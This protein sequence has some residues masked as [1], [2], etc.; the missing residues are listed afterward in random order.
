MPAFSCDTEQAPS[1]AFP[2]TLAAARSCK[3]RSVTSRFTVSLSGGFALLELLVSIV[4]LALR[5][6]VVTMM[7]DATSMAVKTSSQHMDS[8]SQARLVFDRMA[9][10]FAKMVKRND[11]DCLLYKNPVDG[12]SARNDAMFFYS[13]APAYYDAS[14]TGRPKKNS[15]ALIGY[16]IN[17]ANPAYP[18]S[19]VLERLGLGLTWEGGSSSGPGCPVFLAAHAST[20]NPAVPDPAT[21]LAGNW[22]G[23][24]STP[25]GT[26]PGGYSNG[27]DPY[28]SGDSGAYHVLGDLVYRMEIQFLLAD[29]TLSDMPITNPVAKINNFDA[30]LQPTDSD[31]ASS[32]YSRG[33][34]WFDSGSGRGFICTSATVGAAAW[35]LIGVQDVSAIEVTLAV[36]DGSSRKII[37]GNLSGTPLLDAVNGI[38]VAKAWVA[39][40]NNV[41]AFAKASG[42]PVA[43]ASQVRIYHRTFS[44]AR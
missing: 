24:S 29:G 10:D 11:A 27:S 25:L 15:V 39:S 38:P 22:G 3:P 9:N 2:S 37:A 30:N 32:G 5:V 1:G 13:E 44:L 35:D 34:R 19:P 42:I 12:T 36:L 14:S 26:L 40:A 21:T 4:V 16:R 6:V 17:S 8:E 23:S 31:D 41:V 33:S 28:A 43:A 20:T 18:N 7:L